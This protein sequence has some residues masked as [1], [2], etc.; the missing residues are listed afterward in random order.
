MIDL[1]MSVH[2][3]VLLVLLLAVA[4]F[5]FWQDNGLRVTEYTVSFSNLPESFDGFSI[6][7]V[8]DYHNASLM[9]KKIVSATSLAKPDMIAITG[10]L[11]DSRHTNIP[12]GLRLAEKL[13]KIS[14]T[15]YI[16]GNHEARIPE[17]P[18]IRDSLESYGITV[19]ENRTQLLV[20][21]TRHITLIGL[22]DPRFYGLPKSE[23]QKGKTDK[24][25]KYYI[26]ELNRLSS[27]VHGFSLLLAHRP[28]FMPEY[29]QAYID[30]ALTGH[31]HGGQFS[32]PF[33]DIGVYV[34]NQGLFPKYTAGLKKEG[35]TVGIIS[36]GIGNSSFP[37]RLFNRPELVK[38]TLKKDE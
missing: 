10:D 7:Q 15:Y 26:R 5:L 31:A 21:K 29:S 3:A 12:V 20:H 16:P 30:L 25:G 38:I 28:E 35:R 23:R 33:T 2:P 11:V 24:L 18:S 6:M 32:I 34:P 22:L 27:S 36:R 13:S 4:A 14:P 37:F 9:E 8:S 17:Y 19:L 1:L